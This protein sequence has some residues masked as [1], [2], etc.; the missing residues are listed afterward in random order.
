MNKNKNKWKVVPFVLIITI[1]TIKIYASPNQ[2]DSRKV[3]YEYLDNNK[4]IH[5]WN[6]IDDYY[7]NAT[8][9]IQLTNHNSKYWT[10]NVFCGGVKLTSWQFYCNDAIPF[11]G[12]ITTDSS[13]YFNMT[14]QKNITIGQKTVRARLVYHLGN[15]DTRLTINPSIKNLGSSSINNGLAFV[16]KVK[17]IKIDNNNENDWIK[18]NNSFYRL[19]NTLNLL[20]KNLTITETSLDDNNQTIIYKIPASEYMLFDSNTGKY[21]TL[22]WSNKTAYEVTLNSQAGQYNSPVTLAIYIGTLASQQEKSTKLYW[23]D[24]GSQ[25]ARPDQDLANPG[26]YTITPLWQ[27]IDEVAQNNSDY[28]NSSKLSI[29]RTTNISLNGGIIDPLVNTGHIL[30]VAARKSHTTGQEVWARYTIFDGNKKIAVF[31]KK[32]SYLFGVGTWYVLNSSQADAITNY[33]NLTLEIRGNGTFALPVNKLQVSWVYF[34][35][36][37]LSA[38][39]AKLAIE[40]GIN[41][42]IPSASKH[43]DQQIYTVNLTNHQKKGKFDIVAIL[44]NQTWAF[45]YVTSD[46]QFTNVT[47]LGKIVN[48]WENRSLSYSEIKRQVEVLINSTKQ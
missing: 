13:T 36:P 30:K 5:F 6:E 4:V 34:E 10:H 42:S 9:G 12:T 23:I 43:Y 16:W 15:N 22:E 1:L 39:T 14:W 40:D 3:G 29:D 41:T 46:E 17:D 20:F 37:E 45:N 35:V 32:L 18:I 25:F 11:S 31:H 27:K 33:N 21:L 7:L 2:P 38:D 44:G 24:A 48:V 47:K 8:S 26:I 19:N 28:I